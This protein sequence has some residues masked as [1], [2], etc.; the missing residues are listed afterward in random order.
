ME[1]ASGVSKART[2]RVNKVAMS[3]AA[4]GIATSVVGV[5]ATQRASISAPLVDLAALIVVGSSTHPDGSGNEDFFQGMF[6]APP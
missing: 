3:V 4:V 6:N 5:A 1:G 2:K